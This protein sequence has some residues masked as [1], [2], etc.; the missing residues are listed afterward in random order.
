MCPGR[1]VASTTPD[2]KPSAE[3]T[4]PPVCRGGGGHW[5]NA[6]GYFK[7]PLHYPRYTKAQYESMD[8]VQLDLLLKEYGLPSTGDVTQKRKDAM[9]H[10]LWSDD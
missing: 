9:G 3:A 8:E 10:F 5:H 2:V 4:R 6:A 1:G 7:M